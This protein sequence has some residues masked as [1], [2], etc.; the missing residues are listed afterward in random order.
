MSFPG[1]VLLLLAICG[2]QA[3]GF[4]RPPGRLDLPPRVPSGALARFLN[5]A[6]AQ[7]AATPGLFFIG[8]YGTPDRAAAPSWLYNPA[9]EG[10]GGGSF[11]RRI[12][13][14]VKGKF[15]VAGMIVELPSPVTGDTVVFPEILL[16]REAEDRGP[17]LS[18]VL[19]RKLNVSPDSGSGVLVAYLLEDN[20]LLQGPANLFIILRFPGSDS[21]SVTVML[22][23]DRDAGL[24][25]G[26]SFISGPDDRFLGFEQAAEAVRYNFF[27][28][29]TLVPPGLAGSQPAFGLVVYAGE[30]AVPADRPQV[31]EIAA[32]QGGSLRA[33]LT[34]P[35][36]YAD[37]RA[38]P[39][40][41]SRVRVTHLAGRS[42]TDSLIA[43]LTV[44]SGGWV[45]ILGLE[46]RPYLL[47]FAALTAE[48]APGLAGGAYYVL[49]VDPGEP[50]DSREQATPLSWRDSTG[51]LLDEIDPPA[52]SIQNVSDFDFFSLNLSA[53]DSLVAGFPGLAGSWSTLD[54]VLSLLD[55]SGAVL[56]HAEGPEATASLRAVR[57]GR[58]YILVNDRALFS[59]VTFKDG[60]SRIY[61]LRARRLNRRGDVDGNGRVDYRDAFLVFFLTRGILDTLAFTPAQRLAADYDGDGVVL[62]DLEDFVGV[63]RAAGTVPSRDPENPPKTGL[64]GQAAAT[65]LAGA[66]TW[67][68][69]FGDGSAVR[70]SLDRKPLLEVPGPEAASLLDLLPQAQ[71]ASL[72]V[73][74]DESI[75][76]EQ[77]SPNPFNP[78]TTIYFRLAGRTPV[79]LEVFDLRGRL[80]R[81]LF[82]GELDQGRHGVYWDGSDS[83]G[84]KAAS[85]VYFYRLRAG[86]QVLTRKMLLVK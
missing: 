29:E 70:L 46:P 40:T 22:D 25:P 52:G 15:M 61:S 3:F 59:G 38:L 77:N 50:N 13:V 62:G 64:T 28:F 86:G 63:L 66:R 30:Q 26:T 80:L 36:F 69:E 57:S 6:Q 42:F 71:G 54:P 33:R 79:S 83:R 8:P 2:A 7:A 37:G 76:L 72:P 78:S 56:A 17:D 16:A 14:P 51:R 43:D 84:R 73:P 35:Q 20:L 41:L 75:S 18:R 1:L 47:R 81:T 82:S 39:S 9:G 65:A 74:V 27:G 19:A 34:L 21:Q 60:L 23:T 10:R 31:K 67:R 5:P 55:S 4:Q 11:A 32:G 53:G 48:G 58:Y 44:G 68:L 12:E 85:G 24:F 45:E 49:P